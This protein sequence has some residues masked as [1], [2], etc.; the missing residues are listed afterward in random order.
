MITRDTLRELA[1]FQSPAEDAV[2]F[3]FQ[4]G[5]PQDKSHRQE[6]ILVKDLVRNAIASAEKVGKN[7]NV[8]ASLEHILELS[9][10]LHG[11]RGKGKAVFASESK[12]LWREFDVP[13]HL[14]STQLI[15]N[16][17]FHLTPLTCLSEVL[18]KVSIALVDRTRA[19]LFEMSMD[20]VKEVADFINELTRRGR[21]D[22]FFGYDAGHAE[23]RVDN[24]TTG[25]YRRVG[26]RLMELY[27]TGG[28]EAFILGCHEEA[29]NYIEKELHPYTLQRLIGHFVADPATT[30]PDEVRQQAHRILREHRA[31]QREQLV[32]EVLNEAN[33]ENRG[34]LGL[35]R[36]LKSLQ[37]GEVQTLVLERSFCA[38]G[39]ECPNCSSLD[40][41]RVKYCS[42][43][44]YEV[45]PIT[46]LADAIIG[47]ALGNGADIVYVPNNAQLQRHGNIAALLRFRAERNI[48]GRVAV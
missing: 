20:D 39:T 38:T 7:G 29:R 10:Q 28:I 48:A 43:C 19:R 45:Q 35:R 44:S 32:A 42:F 9:E 6:A 5:V 47:R 23:R 24:E 40:M 14:P 16:R 37:L 13:P 41:A 36:V 31:R 25:H 17:R 34:A 1:A 27:G 11:N 21:S 3:Y 8:R 46:D 30:S 22:G 33:A 15:V 2:T 4:P 12:K 18:G 26:E